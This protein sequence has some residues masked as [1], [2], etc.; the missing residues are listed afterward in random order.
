MSDA[1]RI[2]G[3]N[4]SYAERIKEAEDIEMSTTVSRVRQ[5]QNS[6]LFF[7]GRKQMHSLLLVLLWPQIARACGRFAH[8]AS[9]LVVARALHPLVGHGGQHHVRTRVRALLG[10]QLCVR[11]AA[12][13]DLRLQREHAQLGGAAVGLCVERAGVRGGAGGARGGGRDGAGG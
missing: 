10:I 4:M 6:V 1:E 11:H 13:G 12:L 8:G 2:M 5:R 9:R 7:F 3:G